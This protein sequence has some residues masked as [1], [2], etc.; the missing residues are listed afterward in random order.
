M[1]QEVYHLFSEIQA[2]HWWFVARRRI[3]ADVLQR[4]LRDKKPQ[5]IAEIGCGTGAM[6]PLLAQFGEVWGL[7]NSPEAVALCAQKKLSHVYLDN[8]P[9]WRQTQF[10]GMAFF[11]VIEHVPDDAAFMKNYLAQIEPGG[12]VIITVPAFMFLWSEHD[13]LNRHYRRYH[14]AQ[15]RRTI[16]AAGLQL[17]RISYFNTLL[18]PA[19]ALVR[20]AT[21]AVRALTRRDHGNGHAALRTDFERNVSFLNQPLQTLF[22]CER[23]ALR[24][25]SFP[26]GTSLLALARKPAPA[27]ISSPPR[28]VES[29]A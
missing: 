21:K 25:F 10:Q 24:H 16:A 11:D 27:R 20:L 2:T 9:A 3:L 6:L 13:V 17:E 4:Y 15:L 12:W 22:A 23:F 14:A 29:P 5:R 28:F 8:D 18:F 1:E 19:I 26:F 7:D